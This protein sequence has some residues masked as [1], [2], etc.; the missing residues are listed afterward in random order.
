MQ[1]DSQNLIRETELSATEF[2]VMGQFCPKR[3]SLF[4]LSLKTSFELYEI[5]YQK[6]RKALKDNMLLHTRT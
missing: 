1:F 3:V 5:A 2:T 4:Y 6:H